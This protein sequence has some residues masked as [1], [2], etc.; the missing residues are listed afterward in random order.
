MLI[1][2]RNLDR[3]RRFVRDEFQVAFVNIFDKRN[4]YRYFDVCRSS[5]QTNSRTINS[6]L[7]NYSLIKKAL[8]FNVPVYTKCG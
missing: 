8:I 1:F 6:L 2:A 3:R 7:Y 5:L 4:V